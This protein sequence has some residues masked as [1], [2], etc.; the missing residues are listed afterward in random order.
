M[1]DDNV[2]SLF[3]GPVI[4]RKP[5]A[6]TVEMLERLAE[7]ARSGEIV[8]V[9]AVVLYSDQANGFCKAGSATPGTLGQIALMQA[10]Y[11]RELEGD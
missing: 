2:K 4:Q 5:D 9:G 8:G 6:D 1:S 11:V 7:K 3:G 10:A